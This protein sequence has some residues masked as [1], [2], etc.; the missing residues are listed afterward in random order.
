M[1]RSAGVLVSSRVCWSAH[2]CAGE[3][4]GVMASSRYNTVQYSQMQYSA[5][6]STVHCAVTFKESAAF[7]E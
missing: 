4:T 5:I 3:L 7:E 1:G 6:H 2:G